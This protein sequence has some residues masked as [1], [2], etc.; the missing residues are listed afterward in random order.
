[1]D[2]GELLQKYGIN[3]GLMVY[4]IIQNFRI[5]K[6]YNDYIK[7]ISAQAVAALDKSTESIDANNKILDRVERRLDNGTGN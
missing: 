4:F 3:V 1:M 6:E 2:I 5:S 7:Q